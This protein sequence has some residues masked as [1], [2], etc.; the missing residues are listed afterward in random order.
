MALPPG[1]LDEIR[2]RTSIA[3]VVGRKLT[4]DTR[5]SNPSKGDWWAPCP[6][7]QEKTASFHVDDR[8]GYYYC[9]GCHAK[10]DA[11]TYLREAENMSFMEAVEEL[12]TMAG[13]EMPAPDPK[14]AAQQAKRATLADVMDQAVNFFRLQLSTAQGRAA[15]DYL[16]R[17]GLDAAALDR[18]E[19][20]YA[21]AGWEGLREALIAKGA[22]VQ[23]LLDCGLV[24]ASDKGRA[25]YDTF[26]DRIM[27]P[28]RDP[29]G[30][31]IAFGGRAMNPDD[32][33][34]YLN[35]PDTQLFDKGHVLYN[36][37]PARGAAGKGHALILAEGYMDV[38]ALT[39]AGFEGAVAPLGTAITEDQ[40]HLLWR[41]S[42]EPIIALD[43]DRAGL[44]AG[45]RLIDLALPLLETGRALRFAIL[46]GGQDPDDLIKAKGPEAMQA[47]L[48]G[49]LPMVELLWQRE[50]RDKV[51]DSPERRAALDR[52][53]RTAVAKIPDPSVR[54]HYGHALRER[55]EAF[56]GFSR[57]GGQTAP[58]SAVS[59]GSRW[60]ARSG[61]PGR[62]GVSPV[63]YATPAT[64]AV[65]RAAADTTPDHLREAVILSSLIAA[66][67]LIEDFAHF[68][69]ET[70]FT[71]T[72]HAE[73][74]EAL[75]GCDV[76]AAPDDVRTELETRLGSGALESLTSPRH[77]HLS[78]ALRRP[79]DE[80]AARL[81][82]ATEF[83]RLIAGRGAAREVVEAM[84]AL[85]RGAAI[86][87]GYVD[88]A[89]A[90]A[91]AEAAAPY[92][93]VPSAGRE[94][95]IGGPEAH[96]PN[97]TWNHESAGDE[98]ADSGPDA[99]TWRLRQAAQAR[100][101]AEQPQEGDKAD[102][103][104]AENGAL[105]DRDERSALHRLLR[106]IE[107]GDDPTGPDREG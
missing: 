33:A 25:P 10:G 43:G 87:P 55:R 94:S 4:W 24:R 75:L 95:E 48:D 11:I 96:E 72:G 29:R 3:E 65:W 15:R 5:K 49:A 57:S 28:I 70:E 17:R 14:A 79:G 88:G 93:P 102:F 61:A 20:G 13:M 100:Q 16:A 42:D 81:C 18:F 36:H 54:S 46:L 1:F 76:L 35:S 82:V 19:I 97:G 86:N 90:T 74:A 30:R 2:S 83:A 98:D 56:F 58:G 67:Q 104:I 68:L 34:K 101:R 50:T 59:I 89:Q 60:G 105:I 52:A 8:Q 6:F 92:D 7:H 103:E 62:R 32:G 66:P 69:E 80:A 51:F 44:R 64:Q 73:I 9:F 22:E 26:R 106:S 78:P 47:A 77:L 107:D 71:G 53:L 99:L 31:A 85:G 41:M 91:F 39:R 84:E 23:Q 12:A 21:P 40:L 38:I 45:E 63:P 37:G 27:F